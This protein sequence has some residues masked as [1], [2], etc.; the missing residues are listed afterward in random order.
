MDVIL[1]LADRM[2]VLVNGTALA[3]GSPEV[4]PRDPPARQAHLGYDV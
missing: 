4:V 1:Q 3:D 2:T